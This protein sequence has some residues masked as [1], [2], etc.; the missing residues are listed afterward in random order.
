MVL[1]QDFDQPLAAIQLR[2]RG[3]VEVATELRESSQFAVLREFQLQRAGNLAHGF[4]LS[5]AA[6]AAYRETNVH[7]GADA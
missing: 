4:N 2:L 7:C 5:V 6:Y 3:F 1:L